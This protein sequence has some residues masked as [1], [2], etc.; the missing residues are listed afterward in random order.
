[1]IK[2]NKSPILGV[3]STDEHYITNQVYTSIPVK[4]WLQVLRLHDASAHQRVLEE[5]EKEANKVRTVSNDVDITIKTFPDRKISLVAGIRVTGNSIVT[6]KLTGEF[7]FIIVDHEFL[8]ETLRQEFGMK[9]K[10]GAKWDDVKQLETV[11]R[12]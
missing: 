2:F 9:I 1:M 12:R 11:E 8:V 3:I 10:S 4:N 5:I 6:N 7:K